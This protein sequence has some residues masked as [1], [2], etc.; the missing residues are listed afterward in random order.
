MINLNK[1]YT[2]GSLFAGIGGI[3]LAFQ[4]VGCEISW[5]NE[6]DKKSCETY[7][8]NFKHELICDDIKNLSSINNVDIITAGFP[9]QAFSIAGFRRGFE[10]DR[11]LIFFDLLNIKYY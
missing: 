2:V 8:H 1:R 9:C 4:N 6:I 10:D 3:D 5:A 7:S 11:G